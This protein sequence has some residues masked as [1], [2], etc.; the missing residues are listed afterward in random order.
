MEQSSPPGY[1]LLLSREDNDEWPDQKDIGRLANL[2]PEARHILKK[3]MDRLMG[4]NSPKGEQPCCWLDLNTMECRFYEHRPQICRD[5][6]LGDDSCRA[7]R[8]RYQVAG[9]VVE[10]EP[11]DA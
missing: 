8:H 5:L 6:E 11:G 1:V 2:P 7:W 9:P 10:H 3:Y 4:K